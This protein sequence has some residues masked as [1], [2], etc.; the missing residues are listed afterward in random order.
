[1]LVIWGLYSDELTFPKRSLAFILSP[2]KVTSRLWN[3]LLH[4]EYP[5]LPEGFGHHLSNNVIYDEGF[6]TTLFE[7]HHLQRNQ[8]QKYYPEPPGGAVRLKVAT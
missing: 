2:C 8:K 5:C 1:M 4:R 7:F 6:E 3:I